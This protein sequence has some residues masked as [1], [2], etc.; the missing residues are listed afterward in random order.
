MSASCCGPTH[1]PNTTVSPRFRKA[2]WIALVIN[3][4]M[5][6]VEVVAGLTSGSVSLWADAV[7]FA[8]DTANYAISLVVLSMGLAWRA[9]AAMLKGLAMTAFGVFVL[10]RAGWAALQG[11]PPEPMTMGVIGLIALLANAGV[12]WLLYAFRD[13]DANMCSVWLCSRNDAIGNIAV[14][15]AAAGVLGTG[16]GLPDILVAV[17][18]AVLALS[19][20]ITVI[21]HARRELAQCGSNVVT[22]SR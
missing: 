21:R 9:R 18:M 10:G 12:A 11:I 14:M 4:L 13:G 6:V 7:D 19:S 3:G 5:F 15:L 8:G 16:S 2:L 1:Q 20:G 17:V 22:E